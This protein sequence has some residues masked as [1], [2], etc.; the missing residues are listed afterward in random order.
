MSKEPGA[1]QRVLRLLGG[2]LFNLGQ[3]PIM[4]RVK[5]VNG[6]SRTPIFRRPR[7]L[8]PQPVHARAVADTS[9]RYFRD[10]A[11]TARGCPLVTGEGK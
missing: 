10:K 6:C 5:L 3:E 4:V 9:T 7:L 2:L 1:L 11:G 8:H